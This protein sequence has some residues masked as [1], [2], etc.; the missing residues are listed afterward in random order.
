MGGNEA[1]SM[2]IRTHFSRLIYPDLLFFK[3]TPNIALRKE[4]DCVTVAP[5]T[6]TL[7]V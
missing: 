3:N 6:L 7:L 5:Q 2:G 4:F 1:E